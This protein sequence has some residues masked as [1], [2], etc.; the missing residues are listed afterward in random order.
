MVIYFKYN[1]KHFLFIIPRYIMNV[2]LLLN[3]TNFLSSK[4][5]VN[6]TNLN[7]K[8]SLAIFYENK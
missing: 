1:I 7:K 8:Q 4:F 3:I 5:L 6:F 2:I